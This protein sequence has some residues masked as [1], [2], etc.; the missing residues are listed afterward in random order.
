MSVRPTSDRVK[1]ALFN[2]LAHRVPG[3]VFLDLFAGTGNVGI[4]ALSR[5]AGSVI[6][7][8]NNRKN[9]SVIRDNLALTGLGTKARQLHQDVTAALPLLGR[10]GQQFD[11]VFMDPPYLK[12]FESNTLEGIASHRL[13]KPDGV[14][15]I[16][17]S[18]KDHLPRNI[19]NLE[20]VRQE[21]YGDSMLSFYYKEQ[22]TGEGI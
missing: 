12:G 4:E 15:I 1:E 16:E 7:V 9:G 19:K 18:K 2:I 5:G 17:S 10:E 8:E 3:A 14:V 13:L 22:A 11:I 20:L 6:F 21:K